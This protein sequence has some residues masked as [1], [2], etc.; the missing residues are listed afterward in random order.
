MKISEIHIKHFRALED[1]KVHPQGVMALVGRNNSGKS[2]LLR[3]LQIFSEGSKRLITRDCFGNEDT[4]TPI[5]IFVTYK[6]LSDWE[7]ERLGPWLWDA[8]TFILGRRIEGSGDKEDFDSKIDTIAINRVPEPEWLQLDKINGEAITGWWKERGKL[9]VG[10][11]DFGGLLGDKKPQVGAWKEAA[12]EFVRSK[13]N[14]IP[15]VKQTL[16]NPR[17]ASNVLKG[18][19]PELI[20]VPAVRDVSDE[21]KVSQTS[22]FGQLINSILERISE[23][24]R[25]EIG[26]TLQKVGS[27][28]NRSGGKD[29][30]G[31]I[32]RIEQELNVL[33]NELMECDVEI[34]I[35]PP[36]VREMFG[37]A[38]IFADDGF[39]T[40]IE[41]KGH[42]MQ[43]SMILSILREYATV[44]H[45]R[46]SEEAPEERTSLVLLE[47]PEL[48]LH[49][50]SQRTFMEVIQRIGGG[51]DQ[52]FFST[53]SSL[54]V[55]IAH[56]DQV[57]VVR[58]AS[59]TPFSTTIS[60][61]T[62][63]AILD[64]LKARK[65]VQG[66][67]EG[68]RELYSNIF[69]PSINEG[70]FADKV[71]IVEGE[72]ELYSIPIYASV[73]GFDLNRNNVSVVT[74]GGKDSVDRVLRVMN[75]FEISTYVI[76]DADKHKDKS[77]SHA[78][79]LELLELLGKPKKKIE[80][81]TSEVTET[82][83]VLE[84]NYEHLFLD[85]LPEYE[86]LCTEATKL[87]GPHGKPVAHRYI[88][89]SLARIVE[90]GQSYEDTI[91]TTIQTII[92]KV[93]NLKYEKSVLLKSESEEVEA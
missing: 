23:D 46:K 93:R 67:V 56:F 82:Y 53:H 7:R 63:S 45:R 89:R 21:T 38:R 83:T 78:T 32:E 9:K 41:E 18:T 88:A 71:V 73:A 8:D 77:S 39:R 14:Q 51:N 58:R 54:F 28:L 80:D 5:E 26:S 35:P 86:S 61:L 19:L 79:T 20:F 12:E 74:C 34:E 59:E 50:Q 1:V 25:A 72:S 24:Q 30:L 52:V 62:T 65:G 91:P 68:I 29:R 44:V 87:L 92:E 2:S 57:T 4:S 36:T 33:M 17:G 48:Y 11:L 70:F 90:E 47:E 49:P 22:P 37:Q 40:R 10:S 55:D 42:G 76:F 81:V 60:Q 85:E 6:G 66:T 13:A 84:K 43:R 64:D 27:R 16:V 31:E 3:A 69:N 15:W 75:G